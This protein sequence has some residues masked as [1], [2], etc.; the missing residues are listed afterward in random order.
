[1]FKRKSLMVLS[2]AMLLCFSLFPNMASAS[3][4]HIT[5]V[6]GTTKAST[7]TSPP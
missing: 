5:S 7:S 1:M 6:S 3:S 2:L 4:V